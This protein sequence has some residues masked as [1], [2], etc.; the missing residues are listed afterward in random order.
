MSN[1][2][3]GRSAVVAL[4]ADLIST[5]RIRG[6]G[7][8]TGVEVRIAR[9]AEDAVQRAGESDVKLVV[10]DLDTRGDPV[11]TV[12]RLKA[13]PATATVPILCFVSH[14]REDL[15]KA[16]RE[17]GADLVMARGAFVR[18]LAQLLAG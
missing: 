7:A 8:A 3:A 14:V 6:A 13:D 17:A 11:G 5:A 1:D 12:S 4:C 9:N 2:Q 15:I 18:D 10:I 16:A